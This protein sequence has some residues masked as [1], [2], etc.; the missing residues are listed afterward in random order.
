MFVYEVSRWS[1]PESCVGHF[2]VGHRRCHHDIRPE[3]FLFPFRDTAKWVPRSRNWPLRQACLTLLTAVLRHMRH[4][5]RQRQQAAPQPLELQPQAWALCHAM[6]RHS[7]LALHR[8]SSQSRGVQ[9]FERHFERRWCVK[10]VERCR[11]CVVCIYIEYA[12]AAGGGR[13]EARGA[14]CVSQS[15]TRVSRQCKV[16]YSDSVWVCGPW[17]PVA[18]GVA[19]A[20]SR[21]EVSSRPGPT[22][23]DFYVWHA[24][25][26]NRAGPQLAHIAQRAARPAGG[27]GASL[28]L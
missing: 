18:S 26:C 6:L 22:I 5:K 13:T 3:L 12:G 28:A 24:R 25:H 15:H 4:A 19:G 20:G 1:I 14:R 8:C 11:G 2:E 23:N 7:M 10:G 16:L 21:S 27:P 17:G 9:S